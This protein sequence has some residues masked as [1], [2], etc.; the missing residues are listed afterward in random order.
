MLCKIKANIDSLR[1][2][3]LKIKQ[4]SNN[5]NV[6][7]I[8]SNINTTFTN[9]ILEIS[10]YVSDKSA[11]EQVIYNSTI[12]GS[13]N[14]I[15]YNVFA[16]LEK[17]GITAKYSVVRERK[18]SIK[19]YD[20]FQRIIDTLTDGFKIAVPRINIELCIC[21]ESMDLNMVMSQLF[22]MTCGYVKDLVGVVYDENIDVE[23]KPQK[24]SVFSPNKHFL[25]WW[26]HIFALDD[27]SEIDIGGKDIKSEHKEESTII[28]KLKDYLKHENRILRLTTV[29]D[30]RTFLKKIGRTDLNK[31]TSLIL[32]E[33]TGIAPVEP[34]VSIKEQCSDLFTKVIEVDA[35]LKEISQKSNRNYYPY[36]IMKILDNL[37]LKTDVETRKLFY[38][39]YIQSDETVSEN[40]SDWKLICSKIPELI[41]TPTDRMKFQDIDIND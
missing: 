24:T 38:Y 30:V 36:T 2:L 5:K 35:Q 15:K 34:S 37:I 27:K 4:Y 8:E 23:N 1:K 39:I 25:T 40:D 6:N 20:E 29:R 28:D 11:M 9:F 7:A 19:I 3:C 22:C 13:I 41:Y 12:I 17:I 10:P 26:N 32:K 16:E 14:E 18:Y 33:L 21:G 31:N